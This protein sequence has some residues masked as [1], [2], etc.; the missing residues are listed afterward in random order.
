[1]GKVT[2]IKSSFSLEKEIELTENAIIDDQ[3]NEDLLEEERGISSFVSL[4]FIKNSTVDLTD[5][6]IKNSI[7]IPFGR[8]NEKYRDGAEIKKYMD[9]YEDGFLACW[10]F[11]KSI[12][13]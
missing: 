7:M 9:G 8:D 10:D 2:I 13:T 12:S 11:I 3:K 6:K 1:M 4:M 5:E